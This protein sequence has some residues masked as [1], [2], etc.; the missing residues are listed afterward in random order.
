[1]PQTGESWYEVRGRLERKEGAA[2]DIDQHNDASQYNRWEPC[3]ESYVPDTVDLSGLM[4]EFNRRWKNH[5]PAYEWNGAHC[6]KYVQD[7]LRF[8]GKPIPENQS[9]EIGG[10]IIVSALTGAVTSA[11]LQLAGVLIGGKHI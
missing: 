9:S 7:V 5:K 2:N 11:L 3:G 1:M 8:F 4:T 6:Q 10:T